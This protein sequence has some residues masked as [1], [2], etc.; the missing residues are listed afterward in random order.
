M[1]KIK[2]KCG[3]NQFYRRITDGALVCALC[4]WMPFHEIY[5]NKYMKVKYK[6]HYSQKEI[7]DWEML[8]DAKKQSQEFEN[9]RGV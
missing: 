8:N 2:C 1:E 4:G 9:R 6:L 3:Y 5:N 7:K